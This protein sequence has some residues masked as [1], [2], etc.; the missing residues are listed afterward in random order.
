MLGPL[1]KENISTQE[2]G[3]KMGILGSGMLPKYVYLLWKDGD[4][5]QGTE[6]GP[7]YEYLD[8]IWLGLVQGYRICVRIQDVWHSLQP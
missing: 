4:E 7:S 3:S 8:L 6:S 1:E 5:I 2:F